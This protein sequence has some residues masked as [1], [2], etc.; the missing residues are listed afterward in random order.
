MR[1]RSVHLLVCFSFSGTFLLPLLRYFVFRYCRRYV[2][3]NLFA[4]IT[5]S[6]LIE[7]VS[8]ILWNFNIP[9]TLEI[10]LLLCSLCIIRSSVLSFQ[11]QP[12]FS[13]DAEPATYAIA[14]QS[15]DF[16]LL[17]N[18]PSL[19]RLKL[20]EGVVGNREGGWGD[21]TVGFGVL[22][23]VGWDL[24]QH[25]K[26]AFPACSTTLFMGEMQAVCAT[27]LREW[28]MTDSHDLTPGSGWECEYL[29]KLFSFEINLQCDQWSAR[30]SK[31]PREDGPQR[32]QPLSVSKL[33]TELSIHKDLLKIDNLTK[34]VWN[35]VAMNGCI[36]L[37]KAI[38]PWSP[39]SHLLLPGVCKSEICL[40]KGQI[41]FG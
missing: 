11:Q 3:F 16:I 5:C 32:A 34:F 22:C 37:T 2:Y 23:R 40:W 12:C 17:F 15:F 38:L 4:F 14:H 6:T 20:K 36:H 26:F 18:V 28:C 9:Q 27:V 25:K 13:Y 8:K 41:I 19:E 24:F 21:F 30:A 10:C 35:L 33:H 7:F 29:L 31:T 1:W 39:K